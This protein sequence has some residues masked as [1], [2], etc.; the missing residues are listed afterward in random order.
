SSLSYLATL[1]T[2]CLSLF[3]YT[4]LFR[5]YPGK[6]SPAGSTPTGL[7]PEFVASDGGASTPSG[8][9]DLMGPTQGSSFLATLICSLPCHLSSL[10]RESTRLNSSDQI[11]WYAFFCLKSK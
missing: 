7:Q 11:I 9:I 6:T 10:D 5:S 2:P 1:R 8:L 3:P 4:T